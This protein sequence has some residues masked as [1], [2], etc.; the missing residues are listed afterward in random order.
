M[1][2]LRTIAA[3]LFAVALVP[4]AAGDAA[5]QKYPSRTITLVVPYPAGGLSDRAVRVVALELQKRLGQSVVVENRPGGSGTIGANQVLRAAP[6]GYTLLVNATG[7]VIRLHYIQVPYNILNDFVQIGMI[8]E[9]PPM[10][11]VVKSSAPFKTPQELAAYARQ[12]P[13]KMN[14]GSSGPGTGPA[15]AI[16]QLNVLAKT[17][18]V[19]VPFRGVSQA[20][21]SVVSGE[22]DGAFVYLGNAKPLADGGK[23]R[24]MAVTSA[25]R[26]PAWPNLPT[27][28]E[29]GFPGFDLNGFVGLAAPAKTPPDVITLLNREL[30][31]VVNEKSFRDQF[32]KDGMEPR[33]KNSPAE[34]AAYMKEEIE[35]NRV[36]AETLKKK[37][38]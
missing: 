11:L 20:A 17:N 9:G 18:I 36:L 38:H 7:D 19:D 22:I 37:P 32:A 2:L 31:A 12:H 27:M 25:K 30:N 14:F 5:A 29:A 3:L 21:L 13:G 34:F 26:S 10:V 4:F 33:A 24:A 6:D 35:K 8:A 1:M 23:L 16:V 28:I 15:T